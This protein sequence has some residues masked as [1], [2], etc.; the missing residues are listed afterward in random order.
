MLVKAI[1]INHGIMVDQQM[2]DDLASV[3]WQNEA[4]YGS[5]SSREEQGK[6]GCSH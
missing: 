4:R 1:K 2:R 5:T 6:V 3:D